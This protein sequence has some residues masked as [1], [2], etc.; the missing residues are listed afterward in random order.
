MLV[1]FSESSREE[2]AQS[3]G[4]VTWYN[5][6]RNEDL[7]YCIRRERA[8]EILA[9]R[10]LKIPYVVIAEPSFLGQPVDNPIL[11]TNCEIDALDPATFLVLRLRADQPLPDRLRIFPL[12]VPKGFEEQVN[13]WPNHICDPAFFLKRHVMQMSQSLFSQS[14]LSGD[15][16]LPLFL[17][18]TRKS[19]LHHVVSSALE[20]NGLIK[21]ART[22]T[23]D[24]P[25]LAGQVRGLPANHVVALHKSPDWDCPYRGPVKGRIKV[26]DLNDG[27]IISSVMNILREPEHKGEYR[28]FIVNGEV[29]SISAYRD[30]DHTPVPGEISEFAQMFADNHRHVAPAYIADFCMT[31]K[32]PALVELNGLAYA[33]RY[34]D[35]DPGLLYSD[36]ERFAGSDKS[37]LCE[38]RVAVPARSETL[39]PES[40]E[41]VVDFGEPAL[42]ILPL[43]ADRPSAQLHDAPESA[44]LERFKKALAEKASIKDT[45][46]SAP[47]F[48]IG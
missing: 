37:V 9:C 40:D 41:V 36:L 47:D 15:L 14:F 2:L 7:E 31:D 43:Q 42:A 30:Y 16:T 17:K 22:I 24:F 35:N 3:L 8:Q 1:V 27:V 18:S 33:G 44:L 46:Q 39:L 5:E 11:D 48:K 21:T 10:A 32:G 12:L 4:I 23:T 19:D 38:P 13:Q 29:S 20:L 26:I 34:I 25:G 6:F 45:E 28:A